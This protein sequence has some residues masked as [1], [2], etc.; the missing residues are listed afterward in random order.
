MAWAGTAFLVKKCPASREN[1]AGELSQHLLTPPD[2]PDFAVSVKNEVH[3]FV[4]ACL[5]ARIS[6]GKF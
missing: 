3:A 5:Y 4:S 2:N 1:S 6:M